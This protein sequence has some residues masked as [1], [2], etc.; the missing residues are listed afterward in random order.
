MI[1]DESLYSLLKTVGDKIS[2]ELD[3]SSDSE[4]G[5]AANDW[6]KKHGILRASEPESILGRLV[7]FNFYLKSTLYAYYRFPKA[8]DLPDLTTTDKPVEVLNEAGAEISGDIFVESILDSLAQEVDPSYFAE[9]LNSRHRLELAANASE[10]IGRLFEELVPNECRRQLGQ[11]RTPQHVAEFMARWTIREKEDIVLDPGMGAGVITAE[12]YREKDR[13]GGDSIIGD[14]HGIDLSELAI[15]MTA[16]A[17]KIMNGEGSPQLRCGDFMTS[18]YPGYDDTQLPD[19]DSEYFPHQFDAI[20]SNPPY[21]RHHELTGADKDSVNRIAEHEANSSISKKSP[22][23]LYFYIHASRLLKSGGR[24]AFLTPC[25]F[26]ETNYGEDLKRFLLDNFAIRAVIMPRR[27][28]SIFDTADTTSCITLL[29]KQGDSSRTSCIT[30]FI[31]LT[32]EEWPPIDELLEA[33]NTGRGEQPGWAYINTVRQ[34]KLEASTKWTTYL[35]PNS[36]D[37]FPNL[38]PF[39]QFVTIKRGIATGNNDFFCLS[40]SEVDDWDLDTESELT[41]IVRRANRLDHLEITKRDWED[42]RDR[43]DEVYLLYNIESVPERLD[44]LRE[45]DDRATPDKGILAYLLHGEDNGVDQ[46]YITSGREIWYRVE[47]REVPDIL[48]DYMSTTG[49]SFYLNSAKIRS[50]NNLHNIYLSDEFTT[51]QKKALLAYLNSNIVDQIVEQSGRTLSRQLH[52]VE[53]NELKE[54]P[55]LDP[56]DMTNADISRLSE[57]FD[58]LDSATRGKSEDPARIRDEIDEVLIDILRLAE[59]PPSAE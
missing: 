42:W 51:A 1:S 38:A 54:V 57:L 22:M 24:M 49:F 9:L 31:R 11:F 19:G 29:E 21:S 37:V 41:P 20:V 53:P 30:S 27:D 59:S 48:T 26:L 13:L 14:I 58:E 56:R 15:V 46:T 52:K 8:P 23:Y 44:N 16:T 7:G 39:K 3:F 43:D 33:V 17:L 10:M 28:S 5:K 6:M 12:S 55:V 18:R 36:V 45:S 35:N 50:L 34:S 25:E 32:G 2:N 47:R 40:E 4:L